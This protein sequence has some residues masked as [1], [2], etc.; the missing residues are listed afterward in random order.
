MKLSISLALLGISMLAAAPLDAQVTTRDDRRERIPLPIPFP[1]PGDDR[2]G[3]RVERD[4]DR[5][6]DD[7]DESARGM[8]GPKKVPKGH[9]PPAGQCRVW[10]DGVPPGHQP[11]VTDCLS[12]ERDRLRY[13][14]GARVIYGDREA[15]PG[16]GKSKHKSG[17]T[18]ERVRGRD[19]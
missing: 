18:R 1:I 3:V 9:L 10:V 13:G 15:F 14:V 4:D 11:A 6:D 12:A 16:R 8:R 7:R 17:K 2:G 19:W 5:D